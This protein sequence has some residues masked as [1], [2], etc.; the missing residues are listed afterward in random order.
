MQRI[1]IQKVFVKK[2]K[3]EKKF[4]KRITPTTLHIIVTILNM[5]T[6]TLSVN[7]CSFVLPFQSFDFMDVVIHV[8]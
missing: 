1:I 7:R 2:K 5:L 6:L 3:N 4:S 8:M